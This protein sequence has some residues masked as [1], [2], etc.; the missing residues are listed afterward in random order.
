MPEHSAPGR[1][2]GGRYRLVA[3]LGSGGMGKVWRA[4]DLT[5]AIDVAIKEVSLPFT[6]SEA[7]HAERLSRA[8]R[9]ARNTVRL[10]DQ[11]GIVTVHDVVVEDGVPWMVMQL[12]NGSSLS[13]HVREHGPLSV[14]NTAKV[15]DT[16]LHALAAAHAAGIVHRD[17]KPANVLLADDGRVLLT[18]FGIAQ[19]VADTSLTVTGAIIGSAEYMAPERTRGTDSG[20][21]G[22]LFSLGV[23]LYQAVEGI[24]PFRRD[25]P[26]ATMSA[27]LFDQPPV[28]T[29]AGRLA[30]LLAGLL[31]KE[32]V[33]RPSVASALVLLASGERP[34][35]QHTR[36]LTESAHP[37]SQITTPR[38][39]AFPMAPSPLT[40]PT[41][42][43]RNGLKI[44]LAAAAVAAIGVGVAVG[45]ASMGGS[46]K[47][48]TSPPVSS[49]STGPTGPTGPSTPSRPTSPSSPDSSTPTSPDS[50]DTSTSPES[51]DTS[52][53]PVASGGKAGCAEASRDLDAF[54]ASN[55]AANGGKDF[56]IAAD[57]K[58]ASNLAAD[59]KIATDP[60]VKT[61]IQSESD[62]WKKF[63]DYYAAGDTKGMSNTIPETSKAIAAVNTAC[64]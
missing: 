4:H 49:T 3:R 48:Q 45:V 47:P 8:E 43:R 64:G 1:L 30:P 32:P 23:T 58:L 17:V 40:P 24:S 53:T 22:D 7:Q 50:L 18:D 19:H 11:P 29:R 54:N 39:H 36:E 35:P 55:P 37:A 12:V 14:E 41:P 21:A 57:R 38:P 46:G 52:T 15:A 26:T 2:V 61:A 59:A 16:L 5:L 13:E 60:A 31:A 34:A 42:P 33:Q 62:S 10:R 44:G 20:P 63:A 9:E 56:Q 6:L 51:L 25:T 27:V 28:P